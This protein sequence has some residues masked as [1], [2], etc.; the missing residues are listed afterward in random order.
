MEVRELL[1]EASFSVFHE[2]F[3][4]RTQI[5]RLWG[6]CLIPQSHIFSRVFVF[7]LDLFFKSIVRM[8]NRLGLLSLLLTRLLPSLHSH[9]PSIL[10][11]KYFPT[12]Y[13]QFSLSC[14]R[15]PSSEFNQ[16]CL[17]DQLLLPRIPQKPKVQQGKMGPIEFL[18]NSWWAVA[19]LNLV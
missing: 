7:L 16:C 8:C 19:R 12:L 2:G 10:L 1:G 6:E 4:I 5:L 17:C 11:K 18:S 9:Q 15:T 14:F 13:S 3:K